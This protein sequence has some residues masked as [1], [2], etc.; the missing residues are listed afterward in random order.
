[1]PE[2]SDRED[3]QPRSLRSEEA[4]QRRRRMMDACHM[5]PLNSYVQHLR[6][7]LGIEIPD[8]DPLDGGLHA[9]ALFLFEKPGPMTA[10]GPD[11]DGKGSG[12]I[13]RNNDDPSAQATCEFMEAAGIARTDTV[14]W[15]VVPGWNGT[16]K[17]TPAEVRE[18]ALMVRELV[19][20]LPKL[21]AIVFVGRKAERAHKHLKDL[22]LRFFSSTH[23]SPKVKSI[24]PERWANIP[25]QWRGVQEYLSTLA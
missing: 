12:F 15:N 7:R 16:I 1:M 2:S 5:R 13:S 23:P 4:R 18:G 25:N 19:L 11:Q 3:Q 8:F 22:P 10:A 9:R 14:T 24:M 6:K 17:L 20:L 21:R